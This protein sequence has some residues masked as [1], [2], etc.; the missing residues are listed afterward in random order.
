MKYIYY[1]PLLTLLIAVSGCNT[2]QKESVTSPDQQI[3]VKIGLQEGRLY[4]T[5]AKKDQTI[6]G[7]S[8]L[9]FELQGSS[10]KD[11]FTITGIRHSSF[12]EQWDQPWGEEMTV[13]NHYNEMIVDLQ[14]T[15]PS[16]RKLSVVFRVFNDGLGF[17]YLFSEQENL[18]EFVIMD[19]LTEFNLLQDHEAW[20]LAHD[21]K[22]Y[23]GLYEKLNVSCLDTVCT[24]LTLETAGGLYL[25]IHEANL[26]DYAAMKLTPTKGSTQLKVY[27]T[28]WTTGEKVFIQ[29]PGAT[30]W[31]I[32][33]I[34]ETPGDLILSRLMLN[35]NEP[36]K[37]AD[38]SWIKP[39]R[40]IGIWWGMYMKKH[41]WEMGPKHGA[42]TKNT[43]QYMDFAAKH[44]FSGVLVEGWNPGWE[45]WS[46]YSFTESYPDFDIE[47]VTRYGREKGVAL[48]GHHETGGEVARYE[49]QMED[50][51]AY[52]KKHGVHAVKTGYVGGILDGKE[53]HSSQFGVRH[54]RKII[55]TAARYQ[56][57]ID[58]HEP[59]MP[60]G[61]QRTWP[62]LI[63]QEGVRGQ[64]WDA[65]DVDEGNPPVHTTVIPFT[66]GLAGP[67]DFTPVTFNFEN[68]VLPQTRVQ[69]TIAKQLALFVVLYSPLQMASDMIENYENRPEFEFIT[70]CPVNW[71]ATTVPEAKI[72]EYV[73]IA[74]KDRDSEAWFVGSIT[75][76]HAREAQ[77]DLSFLDDN[78]S[79]IA[80]IYRDGKDADWRS[81]PYPVE[82]EERTVDS[83]TVLV[84]N[85]ASGGGTAIRITPNL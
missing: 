42:T 15:T 72:G 80:T 23:E 2:S 39:G 32:M 46:N 75:G 33:I 29:V 34:V 68:P 48:I 61:L 20:G 37:I 47:E 44:G 28:P 8:F 76:E 60:T 71:S 50:A 24:P 51:F 17:R 57:M 63:T 52:Y 82:I 79:Y 14:E 81:N 41:T 11:R 66:R 64:E 78:R 26:T 16:A 73:T 6:L 5:V 18:K 31:R 3:K 65:W 59:V 12:Y 49:E 22:F 27:L 10:L 67:M 74:R 38:I 7:R 13:E 56:I 54:Y 36:S 69:T 70:S 85:Q 53:R 21:T 62:N 45:K 19:E 4:Y 83:G 58:N 55:E 35:L 25:T 43:K 9:G 30:P 77:I 1:I 84:I 40:Y